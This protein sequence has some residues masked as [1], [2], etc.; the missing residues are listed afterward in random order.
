MVLRLIYKPPCDVFI[1]PLIRVSYHPIGGRHVAFG[2]V[3]IN[4][5]SVSVS[6]FESDLK[7]IIIYHRVYFFI[8]L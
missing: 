1:T 5:V 7:I 3:G 6:W 8:F 4:S 2:C